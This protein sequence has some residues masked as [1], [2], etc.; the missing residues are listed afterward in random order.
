VREVGQANDIEIQLIGG[1]Y[2][3]LI[4]MSVAAQRLAGLLGFAIERT[5][6]TEG[7]KYFLYNNLLFER[8]EAGK[9]SDYSSLHNP[10]QAFV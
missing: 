1:T 4:G 6:H 2:V 8:N 7:E 3:V 5:D 10:I 9:S